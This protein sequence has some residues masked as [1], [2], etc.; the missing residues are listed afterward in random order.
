VGIGLWPGA[1]APAL[2]EAVRAV[3]PRFAVPLGGLA[4]FSWV[5]AAALM[6]VAMLAAAA[7]AYRGR[8]VRAPAAVDSTWGCGYAAPDARMQYTAS[9]FADSLV[10]LFAWVLR[11]TAHRE[12]LKGAFPARSRFSSH[13]DDTVLDGFMRPAASLLLDVF[14]RLRWMQAGNVSLYLAYVA[15]ALVVALAWVNGAFP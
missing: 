10:G 11:P 13:V 9:S 15:V 4:G 5:S 2:D 8:L 14:N 12:P 7:F 3:D 6:L 1:V